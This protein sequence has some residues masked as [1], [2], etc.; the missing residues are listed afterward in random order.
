MIYGVFGGSFDPP[1]IT[2][3]LACLWALETGQ[4]ERILLV[5]CAQHALGKE[6]QASFEDRMEMC[7]RAVRRLERWVEVLDIEGHRQDVSYT[8]DTLKELRKDRPGAEWRLLIGSDILEET[9]RWKDWDQIEQM[10]PPLVVPR[11]TGQGGSKAGGDLRALSST[12]L[13]QRLAN[14][15]LPPGVIPADVLAYIRERKLY[16]TRGR[17]D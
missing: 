3:V 15:D 16:C 1:H 11:L 4:V 17:R 14:D 10:A 5:P 7:R 12:E 8:I 9:S 6:I 13:R 2:H